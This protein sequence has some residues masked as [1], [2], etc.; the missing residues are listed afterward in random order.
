MI[1]EYKGGDLL[2]SPSAANTRNLNAIATLAIITALMKEH[3]PVSFPTCRRDGSRFVFMRRY[4]EFLSVCP[5]RAWGDGA[6][7]SSAGSSAGS[8]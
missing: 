4:F 8:R 7:G 1:V 6:A 5:A 3:D 2:A